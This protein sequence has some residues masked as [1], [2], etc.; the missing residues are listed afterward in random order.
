MKQSSMA[1]STRITTRG[2]DS[3]PATPRPGYLV[4]ECTILLARYTCAVLPL[5]LLVSLS[6]AQTDPQ[7]NALEA[8]ESWVTRSWQTKDGLPQ[9]TVT[10]MVRTR[11]GYLWVGTIGGLGRFDGALF[12]TFG[13]QD[14][15]HSVHV[16]ALLEDHQ[17]VLWIGTAGGA[18]SRLEHGRF[19]TL[20]KAEGFP[21]ATVRALAADRDGTLWIG[22]EQGLVKWQNGAFTKMG[23]AEG[24]PEKQIMTLLE[25]KQGRLWVSV[26]VEGVFQSSGDRFVPLVGT[27]SA[28]TV[29]HSLLEDR[30]GGIWAGARDGFLW[31]WRE[32]VWRR[33]PQNDGHPWKNIDWLA[34][35]VEG[36][37]WIAYRDSGLY[38]LSEGE[39]HQLSADTAL[40]E[41]NISHLLAD[42][43][44]TL[45]A[46]TRGEGLTR[47]S[48]RQLYNWGV[49]DGLDAREVTSVAQD[50]S[51]SIWAG[52][53]NGGVYR[54][55]D[56]RFARIAD[57]PQF[58][59]Y[60]YIYSTL[61]TTDGSI[62]A[63]GESCLLRF[64]Q[65]QPA[66]VYLDAPFRLEAIRAM[67]EDGQTLWAGT[68]YSTLLKVENGKAS[69][70]AARGSFGGQITSLVR[71][72]AD[73]L[74]IGTSDGLYHWERGKVRAW[75]T[76]DG[77]LSVAVLVLH[78]DPDGTLWVG[79]L[80]GGLAR[81]KNE[82]VVN[83]TTR[84]GLIDDVISQIV[85]DDFGHLWLG[86]NRGVMRLGRK[87]I[88]DL[89]A[90]RSSH[91]NVTAFGQ[92]E[93]MLSEQCSGGHSPTAI[94]VKD[95]R[96]LFPTARGIVEI[97]P[98]TWTN[99]SAR[100]PQTSIEQVLL[101]DQ[102]QNPGSSLT[103][104]P[105]SHRLEVS[106]VAPSPRGGEGVRYRCRLDP[107]DKDWVNVGS[108][109]TAFYPQLHPGQYFFQATAC[110]QA[111]AWNE[112]P[113]SLAI[114]VK[115]Y[116]WQ[117]WWFELLAVL[118]L[119]AVICGWYIR[120][121]ARL[122]KQRAEQQAFTRQ[123]ITTQEQ[124]RARLGRELHDDITQRLARLAIDAGQ[125]ER[126]A[127][128]PS[129]TDTMR[130]VREGLV[131][132]SEDVHALSYRLHPSVL[133]DLGL[134]EA[135]KAEC[136]RFTRQESIPVHV[137]LGENLEPAA[138]DMALGL[139]RVAQEAL[140]NVTRHARARMVTVSLRRLDSGL[141]LTVQ[142]DGAGFDPT[143]P[144]DHP[145]LGLESMRERV[146][147][148][149]GEFDI[150]SAP[151]QGTTILAW[152]PL[153][154]QSS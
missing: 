131:R 141:Q 97:N 10:C 5:L 62:W 135:L 120:R 24:L 48:R 150:E 8:S 52:T 51:G 85:P 111:G 49:A 107:L 20:G 39:F 144:R 126:L 91:V 121:I 143:L 125:A 69:V 63:G 1:P 19:T 132:L 136:D 37:L 70:V 122:E 42:Q 46:G 59:G 30:E 114:I 117:A 15:L 116:F 92:N 123:L 87:E 138:Q 2:R 56:R 90:G 50:A 6:L 80:G 99:S 9:N 142:D 12:R 75:T 67:C 152:L 11:D 25:D 66:E 104:P 118:A 133:E 149:G 3:G 64:R 145:S 16:T 148:L 13:L 83:I 57:F 79:T 14:G 22:T 89:A 77:F 26:V 34:Q 82:R 28:P 32:G 154:G 73:T 58:G 137:R 45:W 68:Y 105:G 96:L 112:S 88:E 74:W 139:F 71:E 72:A 94:K 153:K 23:P 81:L 17:G 130:E 33:H 95:G 29:V 119:C 78:R 60:P 7:T 54:C 151:G 43:D 129:V 84:Q 106:Y 146:Q 47:L 86:C 41:A 76:S 44:G 31:Q 115:P 109:R 36:Q 93:G 40:R 35:G 98:R 103:I 61:A 134:A 108:R 100:I 140:R 102:A 53:R 101:D 55:Q 27:P 128:T 18:L 110:D 113:A 4:R 147:L 124:E 21:A 38:F 65:G 127:S